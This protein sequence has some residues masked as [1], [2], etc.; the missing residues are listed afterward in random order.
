[1]QNGHTTRKT[2]SN[3]A[4]ITPNTLRWQLRCVQGTLHL[5]RSVSCRRVR[6]TSNVV[7]PIVVV[8]VVVVLRVQVECTTAS[9]TEGG[10]CAHLCPP[11]LALRP[12]VGL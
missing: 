11:P 3:M 9:P 8:V 1:M 6:S 12:G 7:D 10:V 2:F 4:F 5:V